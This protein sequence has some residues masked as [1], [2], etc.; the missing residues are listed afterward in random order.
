MGF[1]MIS[2]RNLLAQRKE[3]EEQW[4]Y[5]PDLNRA[6]DVRHFKGRL[7]C[8]VDVDVLEVVGSAYAANRATRSRHMAKSHRASKAHVHLSRQCTICY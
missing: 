7:Q 4:T 3:F 8:E 5:T 1:C 2:W 6:L